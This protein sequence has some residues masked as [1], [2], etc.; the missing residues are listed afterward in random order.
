MVRLSQ[1]IR[2]KRCRATLVSTTPSRQVETVWAI[3]LSLAATYGI[4]V[5]LFSSGYLDVSVPQVRL[6]ALCIQAWIPRQVGEGYPIRKS[7]DHSLVASSP[8][9]IAGSNVLHR[10]LTPSHPPHALSSLITPT[11]GRCLK[12]LRNFICSVSQPAKLDISTCQ[13][14]PISGTSPLINPLSTGHDATTVKCDGIVT[15]AE[16]RTIA[17]PQGVSNRVF[18]QSPRPFLFPRRHQSSLVRPPNLF[19]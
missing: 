18:P 13:R 9:L 2:R 7:Q 12:L 19:L 16:H 4:E 17:I 1:T 11:S 6:H 10:L 8:G 15:K 5:S 3:P 14:T